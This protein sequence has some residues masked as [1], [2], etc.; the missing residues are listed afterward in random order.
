MGVTVLKLGGSLLDL[1]DLPDRLRSVIKMLGD[2]GPLLVCGGGD[3]ADLVRRWHEHHA[4]TKSSR[5]GW[6]WI[7][8]G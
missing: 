7:R 5:T 4:L 3:A 1:A 6:R 2:N 8:S